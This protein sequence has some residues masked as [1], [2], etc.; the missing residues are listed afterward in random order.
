[1]A[2]GTGLATGLGTGL[3]VGDPQGFA[4]VKVVIGLVTGLGMARLLNGLARFVQH[5]SRTAI[6]APHLA[7]TVYL[8]LFAT[9]F[10]WFAFGLSVIDRWTYPDYLF[11]TGYGA[12]IFFLSTLLF[13]DQMDD[14]A[15]FAD[16][17][18]SRQRWFYG[19]LALMFLT[20]MGD[21]ALK[22]A[23]HFASF[24]PLY[25]LRQLLLAACAV[26]GMVV[27][28]RRYHLGFAL[29][30]IVAEIWWI[31]VRNALLG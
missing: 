23:A 11:V 30:A 2:T 28:D 25:P 4:H 14:Y 6:H 13:P 27:A 8:L 29:G 10:W 31:A 24:G 21:T 1:M 12:M 22:G 17:F 16:Y 5:P 26:A 7:W 15:G 9:H 3:P 19:I 18:R 20:D